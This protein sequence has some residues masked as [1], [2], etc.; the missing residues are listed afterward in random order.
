MDLQLTGKRALVTGSSI[1]IGEAIA[2]TLATEG[3]T[4]AVHGRD[5][6]RAER[7]A[8]AITTAG[9]K[10]VAVLGDLTDDDAVARLA[11]EAGRRLGGIDIVVNNA[12]GSGDKQR[13]EE[14]PATDWAAAFDRNVLAAVRLTSRLL[15]AMR[16]AG[17]GRVV[18][19]SSLAGAMPPAMGPDYSAAKAAMKSMTVSL[20]KAAAADGITVNAVSP[21]TTFTPKLEAAFRKMASSNGWAEEAAPWPVVE[22]AVLPHVVQVHVGYVGQADD[23]AHAVAFLCSPLA[24]Y[25][26]GVDLRIDGGVTPTL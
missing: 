13:W 6:D 23:I 16:A 17:W 24:G 1:G 25:I 2:R 12:G 20:A 3:A 18:N 9:G 7:V 26:T 22:R 4:V 19:I 15:P 8:A 21:G 11:E 10:A 14:T 5:R